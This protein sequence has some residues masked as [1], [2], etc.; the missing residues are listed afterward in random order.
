MTGTDDALRAWLADYAAVAASEDNV[1]A[2]V[3][4]VD[5]AILG[6]I[7][8]IAN[9]A[10]LTT[11]LHASTRS[12]FRAW[13][14]LLDHN[15]MDVALPPQA[16]ALALSIARRG[17]ELNVLLKIYRIAHDA[18]WQFFTEVADQVDDDGPD[19]IEVLKFLWGRGGRWIN[20]SVEQLINVYVAER[21]AVLQGKLARRTATAQALLR[22]DH[23]P[24]DETSEALGHALRDHQTA[25][26]LWTDDHHPDPNPVQLDTAGRQL[27]ATLGGVR[28]LSLPAGNREIWL[29]VATR[30]APAADQHGALDAAAAELQR[31]VPGLRIAL[32]R[33]SRGIAGFVDS[34]REAVGA[35]RIA[36]AGSAQVVTRYRDVELVALLSG[37]RDGAAA[38]VRRE[39]TGL[40]DDDPAMERVRETVATYL[41]AGGNVEQTALA[42]IVH[43]N[44]IRYRISQAESLIG[45]PLTERRTE[46]DLALRYLAAHPELLTS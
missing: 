41:R 46:L 29:W 20:D 17:L 45:H 38:L 9:D 16:I 6:G 42:L 22:G 39:L 7:P 3:D 12:Q 31:T 30:Q 35:Q 40:T 5:R 23:L 25:A 26:V 18:V 33:S 37:D 1:A 32:G 8:A 36:H 14:N 19:R 21:D 11:E 24:L 10:V 27:A 4:H 34:H 44:T 43:K 28:P 15:Q 13:L 2:F